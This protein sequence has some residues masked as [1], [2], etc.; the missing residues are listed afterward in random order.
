M[1]LDIQP[2][3]IFLSKEEECKDLASHCI[4]IP[5]TRGID[6]FTISLKDKNS[7]L[8]KKILK[9]AEIYKDFVKV[10]E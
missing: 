3:D 2:K 7:Y 4:M 6:S 8:A 5:L 10:I 1:Q 9:T